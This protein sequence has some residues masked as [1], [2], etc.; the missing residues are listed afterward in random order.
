MQGQAD[1]VGPQDVTFRVSGLDL[2]DLNPFLASNPGIA[3]TLS[4]SIRVTGTSAAPIVVA[5]MQIRPLSA[6]G[7]TLSEVDANAR[8]TNGQMVADAEVFQN[9]TNQLIANATIPMQ[10]GWDR[11]FVAY[12][13][14][15]INGRV[16]SSGINLAFLNSINPKTIQGLDGNISLISR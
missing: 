9:A 6:H 5:K 2:G 11:K 3:G 13:S 1:F 10:L 12:A 4:T 7:N 8:Y 16:H 15:G 14:G